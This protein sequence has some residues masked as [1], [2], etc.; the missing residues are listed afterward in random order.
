MAMGVINDS[1]YAFVGCERIGHTFMY[2]VSD[3]VNPRYIDYINPRNFAVTPNVTNVD[4]GTVGDL[5]CEV[6]AFVPAAESP[7]GADLLLSGNEISGTMSI[8]QVRIARITASTSS[9]VRQCLN[10]RFS[11]SVTA[12]GPSLTYQWAKDGVDITGATAAT[13][14]LD[15][16]RTTTAG[17]YTCKVRSAMGMVITSRPVTVTVSARTRITTEPKV[18]TQVEAGFPV[19]LSVQAT[20]TASETYQ[21]FKRG[22]ALANTSNI[23]GVTTPTLNIRALAFADTSGA[24]YCVVTGG[25]AT[26][27]SRDARVYIPQTFVTLQPRDTTVCSGDTV[28]LRAAGAPGGGDAAVSY[29]WRYYN[30]DNL[31]DGGRFA[32]TQSPTL[33]INGVRPEDARQIVCVVQGFPSRQIRFSNTITIAVRQAP[34]ITKQPTAPN[35]TREQQICEGLVFQLRALVEGEQLAYQWF[36][37]GVAIPRATQSDFTSTTPGNYVLRV[38]GVCGQT[39]LSDTV[40]IISTVRPSLGTIRETLVRVK[41]GDAFTLSVNLAQGSQPVQY[42]WSLGGRA[43]AGATSSTYTVKGTTASDAGLYVCTATNDCGSDISAVV[44]VRTYRD[45][46]TS[47]NEQVA[48]ISSVRVEPHPVAS[49]SYLRITAEQA[50][51]VRIVIRDMQGREVF[52]TT[53]IVAEAGDTAIMLN[54]A[55]LGSAGLYNA[56]IMAGGSTMNVPVVVAP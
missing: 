19:S 50:G 9:P 54:A 36:R 44:E 37:N 24:Y 40:R 10:E 12:A 5:G 23:T 21:W 30:G 48:R 7:N 43:I 51:T 14:T 6:I 47:V 31:K 33:R 2:N 17:V 39:L 32:G 26:V 55:T 22:V 45:D 27:R 34:R 28:V 46:P 1:T 8:Q 16:A 56:T 49:I 3:P 41:E 38:R 15:S 4:N 13:Y 18:L 20:S 35:G 25:C 52:S 53:A 29:Q 11:L 42:Q